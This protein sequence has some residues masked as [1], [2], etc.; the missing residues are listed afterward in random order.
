[1]G[2]PPKGTTVQPTTTIPSQQPVALIKPPTFKTMNGFNVLLMGPT[3]TG[4]TR[5]I[6]TLVDAGLEVFFI[7]LEAGIES[8]I[9]YWADEGK[10]IPANL[11]WAQAM[12]TGAGFASLLDSAIKVNS[13]TLES[14][15]KLSDSN[16]AKY[17]QMRTLLSLLSNFT[18]ERTGENFGPVDKW[19]DTRVLVIDGLTGLGD[20]AISNWIGGKVTRNQGD[21]G[22]GQAFVMK[23]ITDMCD[24][25]ACSFVLLAHVER[26][27]DPVMGGVKIMPSTLGKAIAP[28]IPPKFSD[29][30]LTERK[31]TT[32]TWNTASALADLKTRNLPISENIPP[33]F[34]PLIGKWRKRKAAFE[35]L[36]T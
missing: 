7:A 13:M 27:T 33:D 3:G 32:W 31:G 10:P 11:H 29:V 2:L 35:A 36:S 20:A 18:D 34:A 15:A 9:G 22:I 28:L 25:C 17:S 5:S 21:W 23:T 6:G 1:M 24:N 14:L 19:D 4:K 8:L 16:R 12:G 30:V 26:E